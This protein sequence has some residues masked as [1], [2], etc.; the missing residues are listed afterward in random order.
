MEIEKIKVKSP[1]NKVDVQPINAPIPKQQ[2]KYLIIERSIAA[3]SAFQNIDI[4]AK[5][6]E[7]HINIEYS[8]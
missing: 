6:K 4:I 7:M 8:K 1:P 3:T 5:N 2:I